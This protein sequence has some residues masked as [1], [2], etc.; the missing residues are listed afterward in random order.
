MTFKELV[1]KTA[2]L[3]GKQ[4][5]VNI[6][7]ISE[8]TKILLTILAE[9]MFAHPYDTMEFLREYVAPV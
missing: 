9:E 4:Q 8:I 3:E 7:Q 5:E 2:D 6:A 1:Q